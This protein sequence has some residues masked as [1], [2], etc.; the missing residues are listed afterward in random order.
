[1]EQQL[2][3]EESPARPG[4]SSNWSVVVAVLLVGF[5]ILGLAYL[6]ERRHAA[7]LA[8]ENKQ[9]AATL[10]Q[11]QSQLDT[12]TARVNA[13]TLQAPPA[14]SPSP[15]TQTLPEATHPLATRKA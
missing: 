10:S 7:D 1:M 11:T 5:A 4:V 13:M 9:M 14:P 3:S 2:V 12:L 8:A 6:G 15:A